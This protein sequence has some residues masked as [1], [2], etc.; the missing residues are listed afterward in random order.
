[1][2]H[3]EIGTRSEDGYY[4]WTAR[5]AA[6]R[7]PAIGRH[8]QLARRIGRQLGGQPRRAA[9]RAELPEPRTG[10]GCSEPDGGSSS[11]AIFAHGVEQDADARSDLGG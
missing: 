6:R 8:G 10:S 1:M 5:L 3:I 9:G 11:V 4:W 7:R 2:S